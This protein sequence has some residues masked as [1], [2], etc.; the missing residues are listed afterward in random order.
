MNR[1]ELSKDVKEKYKPIVEEFLNKMKSL[2]NYEIEYM[3]NEEFRLELSDTELR[4]YTLL[5][6]MREFGYGDEEFEDNGWQLDFW[7]NIEDKEE[8]YPSTCEVLCI[9]GCGITFELNL[10]VREFM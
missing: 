10:S 9:H 8:S 5:E 7:I 3:N 4:P 6:L 2:N 1:Y